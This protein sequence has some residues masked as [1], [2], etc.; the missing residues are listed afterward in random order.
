MVNLI[1]RLHESKKNIITGTVPICATVSTEGKT[2]WKTIIRI[3]PDY[4]DPRPDQNKW[5]RAGRTGTD[6]NL[7]NKEINQLLKDYRK[8]VTDYFEQCTRD[9]RKI[10]YNLV[11]E[12]L[13]GNDPTATGKTGFWDIY[14]LYLQSGQ[15]KGGRKKDSTRKADKETRNKLKT[16]EQKTGYLLTFDSITAKFGNRFYT[17]FFDIEKQGWNHYCG[18][19]KRFKTFMNWALSNGYHSNLE[20]KRIKA[21]ELPG[22]IIYLTEAELNT[23][24]NFSFENINHARAQD[25]FCFLCFTGLRYSDVATLT[26]DHIKD[27]YI[28]KYPHKTIKDKTPLNIQLAPQAKAI[29]ERYADKYRPLPVSSVQK[30]NKMIQKITREAGIT[31]PTVYKDF[32]GGITTEKTAPKCD[33]ISSHT[34]R[35]TFICMA[36]S[37]GIDAQTIMK[38]TGISNMET[39]RR[40]LEITQET[41][42]QSV[43][44]IFENIKPEP[45]ATGPER[46]NY[47]L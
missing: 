43:N 24:Y 39:L 8:R 32:T 23:L 9:G 3:N 40:Y 18:I 37:R 45:E 35:K 14:E 13:D 42:K 12:Y 7:R 29:L 41:V 10:T 20:F 27:G 33:L 46:E 4:W 34:G 22:T 38:I 6:D 30:T 1:Y 17:W 31:T 11:S 47:T 16:F 5:L 25:L 44:F 28:V 26:R 19:I 21:K 15:M 36:F 2:K